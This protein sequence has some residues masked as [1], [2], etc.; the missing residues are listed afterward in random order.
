ML[1][2]ADGGETQM[3]KLKDSEGN[4]RSVRNT[5][6]VE[7]APYREPH[8]SF[9]DSSKMAATSWLRTIGRSMEIG[10]I[11]FHVSDVAQMP[12]ARP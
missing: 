8:D 6:P 5:P 9:A 1:R 10:I 11:P 4:S 12:V 3:M 7:V 2:A